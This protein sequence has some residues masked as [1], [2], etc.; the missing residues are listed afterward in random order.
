MDIALVA[1]M[2]IYLV[3]T[4]DDMMDT[5]M[6]VYWAKKTVDLWV[7]ELVLL[8]VELMDTSMVASTVLGLVLWWAE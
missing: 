6:V 3:D 2:V 1:K 5:L 4:K 7:D 8:T